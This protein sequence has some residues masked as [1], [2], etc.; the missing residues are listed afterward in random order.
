[1]KKKKTL[2]PQEKAAQKAA[3]AAFKVQMN[4]A[5]EDIAFLIS[6]EQWFKLLLVL[7]DK[8]FNVNT[9]LTIHHKKIA[10]EAFRKNIP[11][12]N[13]KTKPQVCKRTLGRYRTEFSA[14]LII[15]CLTWTIMATFTDEMV[16]NFICFAA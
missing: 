11:Y 3:R 4:K 2:T 5:L 15:K 13:I 10:F 16:Y 14:S 6:E 7:G 8:R 9:F 12:S 1:M